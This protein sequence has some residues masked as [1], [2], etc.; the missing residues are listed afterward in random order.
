M[1]S[2]KRSSSALDFILFRSV[3]SLSSFWSTISSWLW[4][5]P[6]LISSAHDSH[7]ADCENEAGVGKH[8]SGGGRLVDEDV[9]TGPVDDRFIDGLEGGVKEECEEDAED[10]EWDCSAWDCFEIL[11]LFVAEELG[12]GEQVEELEQFVEKGLHF[13]GGRFER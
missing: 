5:H 8:E 3:L 4:P 9:G 13:H 11:L 12:Y 7:D 6:K 2:T 1:N 10:E